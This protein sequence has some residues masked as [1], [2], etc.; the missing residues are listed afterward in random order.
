MKSEVTVLACQKPE[1][2]NEKYL[3]SF[4]NGDVLHFT[5]EEVLENALYRENE[6]CGDY[7]RLC[8]TVL[9]KRMMAETASYVLFSARTEAQVRNRIAEKCLRGSDAYAEWEKFS[10]EAA[11]EA[12]ARLKELGYLDDE[13]YCERF[14]AAAMRGGPVSHAAL[15]NE[16]VYKKGVPKE[17]AEAALQR[18]Y[19]ENEHFTD[20]EN[21]YRLLAK[22]TRGVIPEDRKDL[23]KLYRFLA[24]K[25]FS[26]ECAEQAVRRLQ[27]ESRE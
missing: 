1:Q 3:I 23:A 5:E 19:E 10:E 2:E 27:E 22:K 26:H 25:G 18:A 4:S 9:A 14:A 8:V 13:A 21:A 24:G 7:E 11:E 15:L 20:S 16:L 6:S 12:I 17:L